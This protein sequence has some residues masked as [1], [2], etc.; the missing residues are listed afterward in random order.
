MFITAVCVLFLI[1][2]KWPKNNSV[3]KTI[4]MRTLTFS[5]R[6]FPSEG[7]LTSCHLLATVF[8]VNQ[9]FL[10]ILSV[11]QSLTSAFHH[12]LIYEYRSLKNARNGISKPLH[13]TVVSF[14]QLCVL[15]KKCSLHH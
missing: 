6:F 14:F 4:N 11:I 5:S 8:T 3:Y 1:K 15:Y 2:L 7:E 10:F 12:Y 9:Y 13:L